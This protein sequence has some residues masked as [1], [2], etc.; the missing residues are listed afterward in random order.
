MIL[1]AAPTSPCFGAPPA[2]TVDRSASALKHPTLR[3][4]IH[5]TYPDEALKDHLHG[6]VSIL[7]DV[8]ELGDVLEARVEHGPLI[9]REAALKAA[10]QLR[11]DPAQQNGQP[12][13]VTTRVSFHFAPPPHDEDDTYEL[14]VHSNIPDLEDTKARTTLTTEDIERSAGQGLAET[15]KVVPGVDMSTGTSDTG[16]PIIRGHHERRILVLYDGIRH[17]SQKW[18]P[19]HG[20]EIDPFSAGTISVIRGAAGVRYGPDAMGG[21]VLIEPPPL[22]S[23]VGVGGRGLLAFQSNGIRPF[24]AFRMD[25]VP[26]A[27]ERLTMRVEGNVARGANRTTPGYVL[28]NTASSTWNVG[29]RLG[30]WWD[31]GT[32]EAAWHRHHFDGGIF[33][34][35]QS[36]SPQAFKAQLDQERPP[37]AD[38][39]TQTYRIDRPKQKVTHDRVTLRMTNHGTWGKVD[40]RYAY[41]HNLRREFEQ[42]RTAQSG[43]QYSFTLRTH[44]LD[45]VY[46]H[47]VKAMS[48]GRLEGGIG[49]QGMFQ[50]NVYRG[51]PLI[52]N[53]RGFNGGLFGFERLSLPRADIEIG[54]RIDGLARTVFLSPQEFAK[55]ENNGRLS[56][57]ECSEIGTTIQCPRTYETGSVS[58]GT[59]IHAVP[60]HID[61]KIDLSSANR[62]P[63]LDELYLSGS[64]P[65]FP[66]FATGMPNLDTETSWGGSLTLGAR[67]L[68]FEAEVSAHASYI[69]NYIYFSP[70]RTSDG[71]PAYEVT[72]KGTW[73]RFSYRAIDAT[74]LGIDGAI[75]LGLHTPIGLRVSGAAV[76]G[77]NSADGSHLIGIPPDQID[78]TLIGRI[79]PM[80][81]L[82]SLKMGFRM[83]YTAK[84]SRVAADADFAL[85]PPAFVLLDATLEATI[86]T[87]HVPLRVGLI[88]TNLLNTKYREYTSLLRY[89]SDNPGRNIH[90]RVGIDF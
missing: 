56:M 68:E 73:P 27:A 67:F 9:F 89:Y 83:G 79:P 57:S 53:V 33:Y 32:L 87:R 31:T 42:V 71:A 47:P 18:G 81:A 2:A 36:S 6:D 17:E 41:Q 15:V 7:V 30:Y 45:T 11:F 49:L 70:D 35:V 85:P 26:K 61:I 74:M 63:N 50:E 59:L 34:G 12:V 5:P 4:N 69:D 84:Q 14:E 80:G 40:T 29:S 51:T 65:T 78:A 60:D 66:V 1:L 86:Q 38:L 55:H 23:K 37:T 10:R 25:V 13:A 62:F 48:F 72:I 22:R 76:R 3:N 44:S 24:G 64:A 21:V 77:R 46:T 54:G 90:A 19:D 58:I 82:D 75:S 88:A 28:G 43:P 52:P 39:W 8:N 16:K 20:T